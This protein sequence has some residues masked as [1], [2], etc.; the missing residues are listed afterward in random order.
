MDKS[1]LF[2]TLNPLIST[3][4][5]RNFL[6]SLATPEKQCPHFQLGAHLCLRG[7][8]LLSRVLPAC[9]SRIPPSFLSWRMSSSWE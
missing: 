4:L 3:T 8:R 6:F 5:F 7:P 1:Y 9:S 2:S